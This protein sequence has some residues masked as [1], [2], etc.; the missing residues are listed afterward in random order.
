[1]DINYKEIIHE[2]LDLVKKWR[3]KEITYLEMRTRV[4]EIEELINT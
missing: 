2:L 3:D 1:M 4:D